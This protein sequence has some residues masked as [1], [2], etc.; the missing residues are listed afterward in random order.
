MISFTVLYTIIL[1]VA[2]SLAA[3]HEKSFTNGWTL[4]KAASD[5]T[6][7]TLSVA[8]V[9]ENLDQ[10]E[11]KLASLATPGHS[12]YGQWMGIDDIES[13]FPTVSDIAVTNW[14]KN[15][16]VTRIHREGSFVNFATD[17]GTANKLL[18]TTFAWYEKDSS[19]KLRTTEYSI[20]QDL[21]SSIDIILPTVFFGNDDI[22]TAAPFERLPATFPVNSTCDNLITPDC[23]RDMYQL[24]D[25]TPDASRGSRIGYANFLNQSSSYADVELFQKT[26]NLPA[27]N[28]SVELING[29]VNNQESF[30]AHSEADLDVELIIALTYPLPVT[31]FIT[32]GSPYVLRYPPSG[33]IFKR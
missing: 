9:R 23:L 33:P 1:S 5:N 8:L 26:F 18:N 7:L 4:V 24:G 11:S 17:I 6:T 32:G 13:T 12:L 15:A 20:P 29:G 10:L 14:L 21:T 31:S 30:G 27:H 2:I 19:L 3:V 28:F 16:G 25:F 22:S